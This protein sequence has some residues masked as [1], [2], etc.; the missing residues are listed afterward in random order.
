[1]LDKVRREEVETRLAKQRGELLDASAV[2]AAWSH[3]VELV[4][5]HLLQLPA[6]LAPELVS[7]DGMKPIEDCLRTH[8]HEAIEALGDGA[9]APD[10]PP[11]HDE[12]A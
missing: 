2:T 6:R 1:M 9:H 12:A 8:V 4:R 7:L 5:T 3:E 10:W 11:A